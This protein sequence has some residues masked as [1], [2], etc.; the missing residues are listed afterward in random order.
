MTKKVPERTC[1]SCG[2][3]LPK[4]ELIRIVRD[5]KGAF[6]LDPSGK[7]PGRGAYLCGREICSLDKSFRKRLQASFKT[8]VTDE[9]FEALLAEV[10]AYV[11]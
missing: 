7:M 6:H 11:K 10:Q 5:S 9:A 2:E 4:R 1:L 3:K 8:S